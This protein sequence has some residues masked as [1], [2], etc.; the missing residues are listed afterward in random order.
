MRTQEELEETEREA[1]RN[2]QATRPK[3]LTHGPYGLN[4]AEYCL[5]CR[6]DLEADIERADADA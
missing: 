4:E 1:D 3:Y 6:A 5:W 2:A